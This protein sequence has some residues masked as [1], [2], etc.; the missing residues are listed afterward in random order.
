MDDA[1]IAGGVVAGGPDGRAFALI[2]FMADKQDAR[3]LAGQALQHLAT[4]VGAA[5]VDDDDFEAGDEL[6]RQRQQT[7]HA[8]GHQVPLVVDRDDDGEGQG[9]GAGLLGSGQGG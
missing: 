1:H 9:L 6:A 2:A 8:G 3:I 5:V 4:A 7:S